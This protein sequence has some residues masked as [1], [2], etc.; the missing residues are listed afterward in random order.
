MALLELAR[1]K[2]SLDRDLILLATPD[3]ESGGREG[4]GYL[5]QNLAVM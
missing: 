5:V 3:E 1:K 4:A 2:V